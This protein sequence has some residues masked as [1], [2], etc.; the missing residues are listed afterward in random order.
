MAYDFVEFTKQNKK[1]YTILIPDML[2]IH[3][4]IISRIF[5]RYGYKTETLKT[6]GAQI[7]ENGLRYTHND[8][9]YP[10]ILVIGQFIDALKSGKYDTHKVA[11]MLFQTGG[12]CRASNYVSLLRKAIEKAGFG[13]VPVIGFSF[14]G[15]EKHSGFKITVPIFHKFIYGVTCGD[16]IMSMFNQCRTTEVNKGRSQEL[17]NKW[18]KRVANYLDNAKIINY[19]KIKQFYRDIVKDFDSIERRDEKPVRVGIVGEIYVKFSALGNNGLEQFLVDEGAQVTVPGFMDFCFYVIYNSIVDRK[20]YGISG[21][22]YP[23]Y[24]LAFKVFKKKQRDLILAIAKYSDFE[25]PT[26]IEHT[27]GLTK[28]YISTGVKMGEGWL[29]TAE[30]LE[31]YDSGIK[32]IICTQPFGCL[33]NHICG[34]G[35]MHPI[36]DNNP[37]CNIVAIDYD[38]G[39][40][41]VN[42]INRIKL[43]LSNAREK[44]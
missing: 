21:I 11:L 5:N 38:A 42:Q 16:L 35:M 32:N 15:V 40:T 33:P 23:V 43:M 9:C 26:P 14:A 25:T 36:K 6:T 29:L 7:T 30:M 2:P 24:K 18:T 37:D 8:T 27:I 13:Y 39:A 12:G 4:D 28:G 1:D 3:F 44:L 22:A 34:K 41:K 10:A 19:R 31:L 20:L 17:V